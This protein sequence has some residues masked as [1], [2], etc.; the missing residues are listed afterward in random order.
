MRRIIYHDALRIPLNDNILK[1][2]GKKKKSDE[3]R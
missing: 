2:I 1:V 3:V